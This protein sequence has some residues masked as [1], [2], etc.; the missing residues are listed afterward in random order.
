MP[1]DQADQL[2]RSAQRTLNT[3]QLSNPEVND[4]LAGYMRKRR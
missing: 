2:A 3:L 4:Y 1:A